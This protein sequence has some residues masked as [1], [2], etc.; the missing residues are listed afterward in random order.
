[1]K[2]KFFHKCIL[3][4]GFTVLLSLTTPFINDTVVTAKSIE[5]GKKEEYKLNLSSITLVKG[6][7]YPLKAY[8]LPEKAHISFKSDDKE[9]ASVSDEGV[10]TANKVGD[11]IIRVLIK[12]ETETEL[13]CKVTVGPPAFS[14]KLTKS[15][16]II[17]LDKSDF[18]NVIL[19]PTNTVEVA[20]FSSKEPSIASV[21][22]GGR[23]TAKSKGLTYVF[24][25]IDATDIT[26][27]RRYDTCTVIVVD[28]DDV[29]HLEAYFN[30]HPELDMI[31]KDDLT[32][33]LDEFFNVKY[34]DIATTPVTSSLNSYLDEK[35]KLAELRATR[36][37]IL[38]KYYNNVTNT[39][40]QT[41]DTKK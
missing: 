20:K 31:S 35:F 41:S 19:K 3:T 34:P 5:T 6:K 11:T 7:S 40:E 33:A 22:A 12:D 27:A 36:E 25:E 38:A 18:L 8:N 39:T 16:L 15:R 23:V 32:S 21:S 13:T 28:P 30:D 24:A 9:I 14:I 10:V 26:G 2:K 17:G 37:A 4:L 1:M 29:P